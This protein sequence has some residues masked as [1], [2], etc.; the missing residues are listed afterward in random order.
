MKK[1]ST[2]A[3][4]IL[5]ALA[6]TYAQPTLRQATNSP[7]PGDGFYGHIVDPTG[8]TAL[9]AT[10]ASVTWNY[11]VLTE[12]GMDTNYYYACT[13]TPYCDSFP[14]NNIVSLIDSSFEYG[15]S[16]AAQLYF[17]GWEN[18]SGVQRFIGRQLWLAYP[19]TYHSTV[20]D[21]FSFVESIPGIFF[22]S[23]TIFDS[24]VSDGYGTIVLPTGTFTNVL[25]LHHI[26]LEFD[27]TIISGFDSGATFGRA[28]AYQWFDTSGFHNPLFIITYDT[29]GAGSDTP[30]VTNAEYYAIAPPISALGVNKP[31]NIATALSVFPNPASGQ[32][33][34]TFSLTADDKSASVTLTDVMGRVVS[35]ISGDQ[36]HSGMNAITFPTASVPPGMYIV[37]LQSA[38]GSATQKVVIER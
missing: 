24:M 30:Y 32:V 16:D 23:T 33:N 18:S 11:S 1:I 27:S 25:L 17:T 9:P 13:S 4:A 20:K 3:L 10:G 12:T 2:L 28:D 35:T 8:L 6:T 31:A 29:A 34:A 15:V 38:A 19:F 37:R 36:L 5:G 26:Y 22:D 21:T 14:G 7:V